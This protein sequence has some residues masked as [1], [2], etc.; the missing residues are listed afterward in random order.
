MF[1]IRHLNFSK[2]K[3]LAFL[4]NGLNTHLLRKQEFFFCKEQKG[5]KNATQIEDK[6]KSIN[7]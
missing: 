1:L 5:G 4:L 6:Y 3:F 7:Y 2:I